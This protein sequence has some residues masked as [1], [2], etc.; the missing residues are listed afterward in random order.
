MEHALLA[1]QTVI[2]RLMCGVMHAYIA[3]TC[4]RLGQYD[5]GLQRADEGI[6]LTETTIDRMFAADLW[7]IKGELLL[8]RAQ[9]AKS[10][11]AVGRNSLA[12]EIDAA[13]SCLLRALEIARRQHARSLELRAAMSLA[14][15]RATHGS[16][17]EAH[18][19]LQ[20]VYASFTEGLDTG[21]L[22]QA[23]SLLDN[24]A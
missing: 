22:R 10:K 16:P 19:T 12:E 15:Q 13:E 5:E 2:G 20:P 7:R 3:D 8:A 14:R 11:R 9:G 18:A 1:Q 17:A 4:R 24:L 23:T 6:E 21:D